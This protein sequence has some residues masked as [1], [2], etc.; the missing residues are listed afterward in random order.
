MKYGKLAKLTKVPEDALSLKNMIY[1]YYLQIKNIFLFIA[2]NSSYPTMGLND[3]T[4][5][6]HRS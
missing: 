1:K 5:F 6:V 4:S 2:S 3:F